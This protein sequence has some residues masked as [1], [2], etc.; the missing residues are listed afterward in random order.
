M[1]YSLSEAP[2]LTLLHQGTSLQYMSFGGHLRSKLYWIKH[3]G[4]ELAVMM[5]V[6]CIHAVQCGSRQPLVANEH[7]L[8]VSATAE[9]DF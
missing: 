5:E 8:H 1:M 4:G 9:L 6:F 2:P 3:S 7:E